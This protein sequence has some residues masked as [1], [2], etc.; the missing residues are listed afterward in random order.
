MLKYFWYLLFTYKYI[1]HQTLNSLF[2]VWQ[3]CF[4]EHLWEV[5]DSVKRAKRFCLN[6]LIIIVFNRLINLLLQLFVYK[7]FSNWVEIKEGVKSF[8][9]FSFLEVIIQWKSSYPITPFDHLFDDS[10]ANPGIQSCITFTFQSS[11]QILA[12]IIPPITHFASPI[13]ISFYSAGNPAT[14]CFF[15]SWTARYFLKSRL[16]GHCLSAIK[17][18]FLGMI[19]D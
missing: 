5:W 12:M 16:K 19:S 14:F 6:C 15:V 11:S 18:L 13:S 4:Y 8:L 1:G 3:Y 2:L 7:M 9:L 10:S 17:S